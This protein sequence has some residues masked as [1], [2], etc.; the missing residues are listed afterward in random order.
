MNRMPLLYTVTLLSVLMLAVAQP[1][2]A[3]G[4]DANAIWQEAVG[5]LQSEQNEEAAIALERLTALAPDNTQYQ[6]YLGLT[7]RRLGRTDEALAA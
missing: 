4:E 5:H 3:E 6:A 7:Y 1:S 2:V